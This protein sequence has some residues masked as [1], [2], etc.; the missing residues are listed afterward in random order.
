V[1]APARSHA[2]RA[3]VARRAA[4]GIVRLSAHALRRR[5]RLAPAGAPASP[6]RFDIYTFVTDEAQYDAFLE[7]ARAA[8]FTDGRARTIRLDDRK[9]PR[10]PYALI[11]VLSA[12]DAPRYP[13]VVHQDVR[14]DQGAGVDELERVIAE[15]DEADPAWVVAGNAGTTAG[16][17]RIRRVVDPHGGP[18]QDDLPRPAVS[19]DENVLLF[20]HRCRPA[21][22]PGLTGFHLYGTDVVLDALFRGG[23]AYVVDFPVTHLSAGT[24]DDS[25]RIARSA[26]V[27]AWRRR[28][29]AAVLRTPNE[30]IVVAGGPVRRL[31]ESGLVRGWLRA[32]GEQP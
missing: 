22:S 23:G 2:V 16:F 8:G 30:L 32:W 9:E 18:T 5:G 12:D 11:R 24:L 28:V 15:L 14:F 27:A 29:R 1:T 25:Y 17:R 6:R 7:S 19:L 31:L 4:R 10:D 13:V 26:F 21:V 3:A 20:N